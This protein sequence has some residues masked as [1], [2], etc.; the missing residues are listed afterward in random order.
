MNSFVECGLSGVFSRADGL[1]FYARKMFIILD[2]I[3]ND[4]YQFLP[5]SPS[6]N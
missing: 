1:A 2:Y 5:F 3:K 4:S 6:I